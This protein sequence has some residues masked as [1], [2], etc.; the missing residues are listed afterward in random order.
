M[1]ERLNGMYAF[2]IWDSRTEK[3][4]MIRDRMGIKPFYYY[5]TADGVLFGSEPKAILAKRVVDA[6]GLR[7][8]LSLFKTP[9]QVVWAGMHEVMPGTVLT[10]D[11]NG[12]RTHRYWQLETREHLDDQ[13]ATIGRVRE[14]LDD[15]VARQLVADV[16]R[17]ILLSGG[18]DSSVLTGLAARQLREQGEELRTFSV[19]FVGHEANFHADELHATP[20]GPYIRDMADHV[21]SRH[22]TILL[23]NATLSD[24]DIRRRVITARDVPAGIGE[25]DISLY[26]LF[27]AIRE[28][29]TVALSGES[30]D[31]I[32]GGYLWFHHPEVQKADTF[33]WIAWI[34]SLLA[35]L[36]GPPPE[37]TDNV[38]L[39]SALDIDGYIKDRY[40]DAVAEVTPLPDES[41]HERRMRVICY[42]HLTRFL[43]M[44]LD[45]KDRL[46]MAVGLEVRVPFCDHRLIE[47]VYNTPWSLKTYDGREK[48][49]L[50]GAAG[51]VLP[52][53]VAERVKSPY[54]SPQ[55]SQYVTTLQEQARELVADRDHPL[56]T[57]TNW[58]TLAKVVK[59]DP[60][61]IDGGGQFI[62][63]RNL[64]LAAW[65]DICRPELR[66]S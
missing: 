14:L 55:S 42:L 7:E 12:R 38:E 27:K 46:S 17:C 18:L 62:L 9:G 35:T 11:R 48:S 53:S 5:P 13:Q 45:R 37:P 54:P 10:F 29:S 41:E 1:A 6:D 43:P 20:D 24:Q 61:D 34:V 65:L 47:Y 33:P 52:K 63:E 31:E 2:A 58:D 40:A 8:V 15:T 64:D 4:V 26:L 3:L 44:L 28:H 50:R 49:L 57:L 25:T 21:G 23:D 19:D 16:P 59:R 30:A 32:F 51:D 36:P 39:R 56:F 66:V 60:A 22:A